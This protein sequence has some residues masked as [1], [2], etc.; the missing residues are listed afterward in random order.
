MNTARAGRPDRAKRPL[1]LSTLALILA[2]IAVLPLWFAL[3]VLAIPGAAGPF[4][5][6]FLFIVYFGWVLIPVAALAALVLAIICLVRRLPG[7]RRS[8]GALL[9]SVFALLGC[10]LLFANLAANPPA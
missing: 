5:G 3:A 10:G 8:L 7:F 6:A 4:G 9:L 2:V 1:L